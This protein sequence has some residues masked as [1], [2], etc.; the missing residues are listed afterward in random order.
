[1]NVSVKLFAAARQSVG[2]DTLVVALP[3]EA[4]VAELRAKL[5]QCAPAMEALL[6]RLMFAVDQEYADDDVQIP[7][8]A[9][10]AC[11]PPVSGG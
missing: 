11:I 3:A 10:V 2:R 7:E 5:A 9:E 4:T 8:G 1:M 6:P